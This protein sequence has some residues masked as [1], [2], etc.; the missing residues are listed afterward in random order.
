MRKFL[1]IFL[2]FILSTAGLAQKDSLNFSFVLI[3]NIDTS[4]PAYFVD[5]EIKNCHTES[6][7]VMD[8]IEKHFFML[9]E[10]DPLYILRSCLVNDGYQDLVVDCDYFIQHYEK[11]RPIKVHIP[12]QSVTYRFSWNPSIKF[13]SEDRKVIEFWDKQRL[14]ATFSYKLNGKW[15]KAESSWFLVNF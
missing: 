6:I 2:L 4:S 11:E 15:M 14:K 8:S 3:P 5:I 1:F 9:C 10:E 7:I 13:R 12:G